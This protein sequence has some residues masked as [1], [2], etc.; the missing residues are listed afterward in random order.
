MFSLKDGQNS[1]DHLYHA[2]QAPEGG[3][4][5]VQGGTSQTAEETIATFQGIIFR[6]DL[7]PF[8]QKLRFAYIPLLQFANKLI[9]ELAQEANKSDTFAKV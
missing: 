4:C 2:V 9:W 5:L 3:W 6:M 8:E 7:P 1:S